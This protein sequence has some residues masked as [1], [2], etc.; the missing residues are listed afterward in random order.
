MIEGWKIEA[1]DGEGIV[2]AQG[3]RRHALSLHVQ[4]GAGGLQP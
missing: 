2:L 3:E 4:S 1:I